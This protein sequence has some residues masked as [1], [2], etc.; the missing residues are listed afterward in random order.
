MESQ[1]LYIDTHAHFDLCMK[2]AGYT[3]EYLFSEMDRTGVSRAVQISTERSDFDWCAEFA[4]NHDN[5]FFTLG[6]HPGSPVNDDDIRALRDKVET[7]SGTPIIRKLFGIGEIGLDYYWRNDN[8]ADQL[9]YFEMQALIAKEHGLP[10]IVHSRDALDDTRGVLANLSVSKGILH[11]FSGNADD[12]KRFLDMGFYI[13]FA[14]NVTYKKA[15]PLQ[16]AA[17]FVPDDRLFLETDCPYLS[18]QPVRGQKNHPAWVAHTYEFVARL[19]AVSVDEL[20]DRIERNFHA[21]TG[22]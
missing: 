14:G 8:R 21:F 9:K 1:H 4:L 22:K 6:I 13:S 3:E 18:P 19:R 7:M 11:C 10:V 5:I 16:E 15:V 17:V 12:A 20:A 2:D